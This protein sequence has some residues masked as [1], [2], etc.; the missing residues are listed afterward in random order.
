LPFLKKIVFLIKKI[1]S[2]NTTKNR[3][4]QL[5]VCLSTCL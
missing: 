5:T 3:D 4:E 2:A 1:K